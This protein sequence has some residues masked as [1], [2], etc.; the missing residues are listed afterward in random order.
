MRLHPPPHLAEALAI[1]EPGERLRAVLR[2]IYA[3]HRDG[4]AMAANVQRDR[5]TLPALDDLMRRTADV[6]TAM[7]ADALAAGPR[8]RALVL[9]ALDFSTWRRLTREGLDDDA[10]AT[11]MSEVVSG[12]SS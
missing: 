5:A 4:E 3:W 10:A 2:A 9:L 11:L 1:P 6:E 12:V 8:G 7:L